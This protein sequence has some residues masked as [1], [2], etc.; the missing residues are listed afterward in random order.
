MK[1]LRSRVMALVV[2]VI[3]LGMVSG[4]TMLGGKS[5][6]S[7]SPKEKATFFMGTYNR[8]YADYKTQV[9][10]PNLSADQKKVLTIR[11][12]VLTQVYPLISTYDLAVASG[13]ATT[14]AQE[15]AIMLLFNQLAGLVPK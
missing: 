3:I 12:Q 13:Q 15:D 10:M 8:Q 4:C 11:K 14:K 9:A 7:M 2:S 1:A 6:S 5:F